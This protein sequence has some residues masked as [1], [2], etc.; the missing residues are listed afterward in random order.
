M[1]DDDSVSVT[2]SVRSFTHRRRQ[3]ILAKADDPAARLEAA[4]IDLRC[5]LV[6]GSLLERVN[7]VSFGHISKRNQTLIRRNI[8]LARQCRVRGIGLGLDRTVLAQQG[9]A[10]SQR[11]GSD[12]S[13]AVLYDRDGK[14]WFDDESQSL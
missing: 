4:T 5:L 6:C 14:S 9:R 10:G 11:A 13:L 1:G 2:T 7:G 3:S 12:L 8:D